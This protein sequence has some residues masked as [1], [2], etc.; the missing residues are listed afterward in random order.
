[1][2]CGL[3]FAVPF[4]QCYQIKIV[5][6]KEK[7]LEY[8]NHAFKSHTSSIKFLKKKKIFIENVH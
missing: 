4:I 6:T 7:A 1:M 8:E 5:H 2:A 3:V